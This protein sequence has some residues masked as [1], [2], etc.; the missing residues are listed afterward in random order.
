[1]T[2]NPILFPVDY[3]SR[4]YLALREDLIAV[5]KSRIP[6]WTADDPADFGVALVEALAYLG[7]VINYYID[8]AAAETF[9]G[10][11][12][13]RQSL[14]N[15]ASLLGYVPTGRLAASTELTFSNSTTTPVTVTAGSKVQ[16]VI[17]SGD[18]NT[19]LLWEVLEDTIVPASNVASQV[20]VVQGI[21]LADQTLGT[22][23]GTALQQF[24]IRDYPVVNRSVRIVVGIVEYVYVQNLYTSGPE[25]TV[26]TYRTD[27]KGVTT[28][29]F[30]DGVSGKIPPNGTA[31]K[32][33]YRV[34]G[35]SIGNVPRGLNFTMVDSV[36]R[37]TD[38]QPVS[39]SGTIVNKA[40][41]TGGAN[42]ESNEQI[43]A[44]ASAA[45][46]TRNSAVTKQD[47]QDI[48]LTDNRVAKA[49]ARGNS[50][51]NMLVYV[52]PVSSGV[53]RTD[54]APGYD[55]Y[56]IISAGITS[57]VA[58][59]VLADTPLFPTG[60]S[61][62]IAGLGAIYDGTYTATVV[63]ATNTVTVPLTHANITV[64]TVDGV[65]TAGEVA[66]F[67][68]TRNDIQ[69]DLQ[70]KGVVGTAVRVYGPR[71]RD[72]ALGVDLSVKPQYKQ[73]DA[74]DAARSALAAMFNYA[75]VDFNRALRPQDVL[76]TLLQGV[77]EVAYAT[78]TLYD[79]PG[80]GSV[81]LVQAESDQILRLLDGNLNI[82]VSDNSG[83]VLS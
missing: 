5:I 55:G 8:R 25:D 73:T 2:A 19:S 67:T 6:E 69:T 21:T 79:A 7:D 45:F 64:A 35:G 40:Q 22:S 75:N 61:V 4:D 56:N 38:L 58:S 76:L 59:F 66:D 11:A 17:R 32:A 53:R 20:P 24:V 3:T 28:V 78:V 52:A 60:T 26:F 70:N 16:C 36:K 72:I 82:T 80:G 77:P 81:A 57:N 54:P 30:G 63:P 9:L 71:Y 41:A 37:T 27:E 74:K 44:N 15:I 39:F 13:Q 43:R 49:K 48:A 83:I 34:G 12:S 18:S 42:E 47:F 46:R 62:T 10:T 23:N 14:L 1:M 65:L 31:I 68:D 51:E 33:T 50:Y 29:Y